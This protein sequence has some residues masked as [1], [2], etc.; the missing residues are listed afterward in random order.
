[1]KGW[2]LFALVGAIVC[3]ALAPAIGPG[4][5]FLLFCV[6]AALPALFWALGK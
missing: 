3:L 1:M 6:W 5:A 2:I 4:A